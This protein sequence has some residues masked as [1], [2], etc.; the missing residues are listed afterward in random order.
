VRKQSRITL[1]VIGL[2]TLTT[3]YLLGHQAAE[4][5]MSL[6][7]SATTTTPTQEADST[8]AQ[9]TSP[10][11]TETAPETTATADATSE[12]TATTE[13][14]PTATA[15]TEP[16]PTATTAPAAT[17]G[18]YTSQTVQ[19]RYGRIQ[20]EIA[21]TDG[22]LTDINLLQATTEGR[23]Y[24]Q[25][26]PILVNAALQAGGTNFGNLSGA[27]FTTQ[28]FKQA[29]DDALAQAGLN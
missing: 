13:P 17:S 12:P 14:S 9:V 24:D 21:V 10:A 3:S 20:L 16:A 22:A 5:N 25:A 29:L 2:S 15:T 6:A 8:T 4:S 26:P 19:Y 11:T 23:G 18:T 28:A 1:G 7:A 27:T